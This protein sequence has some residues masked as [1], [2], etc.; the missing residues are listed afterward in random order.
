MLWHP[1]IVGQRGQVGTPGVQGP[2]QRWVGRCALPCSFTAP[3][4]ESFLQP[5]AQASPEPCDGAKPCTRHR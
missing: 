3:T 4:K 5:H 1:G 2:T